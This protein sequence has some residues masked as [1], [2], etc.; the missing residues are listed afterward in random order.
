MNRPIN[1]VFFII[2]CFFKTGQQYVQWIVH[3]V[4]LDIYIKQSQWLCIIIFLWKNNESGNRSRQCYEKKKK[5]RGLT[6]WEDTHAKTTTPTQKPHAHRETTNNKISP[7]PNNKCI[8]IFIG[9]IFKCGQ[10]ESTVISVCS[11]NLHTHNWFFTVQ[12]NKTLLILFKKQKRP[13]SKLKKQQL[14]LTLNIKFEPYQM[15]PF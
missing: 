12:I 8:G 10:R 9:N 6:A 11:E 5:R 15:I 4:L 1:E 13:G 2:F 14:G 7:I 3:C